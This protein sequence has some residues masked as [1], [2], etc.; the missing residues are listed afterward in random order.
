MRRVGAGMTAAVLLAGLAATAASAQQS[1]GDLHAAAP[2]TKAIWDGW[3]TPAPKPAEPKP[4]AV[5]TP[6]AVG[7]SA[8]DLA[9][10]ARK[11]ERA[12]LDRRW[13]VCD[14]LMEV[15]VRNNDQA[16]Q[17]QI[18]QLHDRAWEVYQQRTS[19][20]F[21]SSPVTTDEKAAPGGR[22]APMREVKP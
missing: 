19:G 22:P 14:R 4:D 11:R 5:V 21:V 20:V 13:E 10:M 8:A 2:K 6:A 1:D 18:E 12:A 17:A 15:A 7:P 9:A 3:F 16:M